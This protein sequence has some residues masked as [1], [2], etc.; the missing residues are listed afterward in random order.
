[1]VTYV[2]DVCIT[3]AVMEYI[4]RYL[5][6]IMIIVFCWFLLLY[7]AIGKSITI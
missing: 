2:T 6:S 4:T 3:K 7:D 5:A 1:M